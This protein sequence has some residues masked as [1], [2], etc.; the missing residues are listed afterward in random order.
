[1]SRVHTDSR[2]LPAHPGPPGSSSSSF[3]SRLGTAVA[4]PTSSSSSSFS[5]PHPITEANR[6]EIFFPLSRLSCFSAGWQALAQHP[7]FS[8]IQPS[9]VERIRRK[10]GDDVDSQ[11]FEFLMTWYQKYERRFRTVAYLVDA[12]HTAGL[13]SAAESLE[14]VMMADAAA[15]DAAAAVTSGGVAATTNG[16][17]PRPAD[18]DDDD[19]ESWTSST[20]AKRCKRCISWSPAEPDD[21]DGNRKRTFSTAAPPPPELGLFQSFGH[22]SVEDDSR[23]ELPCYPLNRN[24]LGFAVIINNQNY[25]QD[26]TVEGSKRFDNREGTKKDAERLRCVMGDRIERFRGRSYGFLKLFSVATKRL[27]QGNNSSCWISS[28]RSDAPIVSSVLEKRAT[29]SLIIV[30]DGPSINPSSVVL[31]SSL[32]VLRR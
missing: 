13:V 20:P 24:P 18:G 19:P 14:D 11:A 10:H 5:P 17:H 1:M 23:S 8:R 28:H 9:D 4:A 29:V 32:G 25:Q 7:K 12:L 31:F 27:C 2:L 6:N 16:H 15:S 3:P 30:S 21:D 22:L 26:P